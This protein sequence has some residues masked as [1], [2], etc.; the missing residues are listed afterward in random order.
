MDLFRRKV[1]IMKTLI[2]VIIYQPQSIRISRFNRRDK[3]RQR[4]DVNEKVNEATELI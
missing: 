2:T 3:R 4:Q 1:E